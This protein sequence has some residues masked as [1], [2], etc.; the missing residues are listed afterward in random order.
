MGFPKVFIKTSKIKLTISFCSLGKERENI[1]Y[2]SY[3]PDAIEEAKIRNKP[4]WDT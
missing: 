1:N 2:R 3:T 4:W